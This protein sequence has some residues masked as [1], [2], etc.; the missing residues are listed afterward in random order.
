MKSYLKI[1]MVLTLL[2]LIQSCQS[3]PDTKSVNK[4]IRHH[5]AELSNQDGSGTYNISEI[6]ILEVKKWK[7]KK[8]WQ[9]KVIVSGTYQNGSLPNDEGPRDYR[10]ETIFLFA[11]NKAKQWECGLK[12]ED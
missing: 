12:K 7:E 8:V 5:Y 9:V 3:Q 6:K 2:F 11:K 4:C 1:G 10:N